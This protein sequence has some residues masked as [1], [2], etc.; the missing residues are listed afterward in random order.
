ME[1][2]ITSKCRKVKPVIQPSEIQGSWKRIELSF[3]V[4]G[5]YYDAY[6][7]SYTEQVQCLFQQTHSKWGFPI[8]IQEFVKGT[9]YNVIGLGDGKGNTIAAVPMR[10]QYITDKG[11][12]WGGITI[13]DEK[14]IEITETSSKQLNGEVDL[15]WK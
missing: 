2:N 3:L 8:I 13:A 4:K 6:I 1:K 5:K 15:N 14:M 12:A 10:K 7:A 11:K 9:E